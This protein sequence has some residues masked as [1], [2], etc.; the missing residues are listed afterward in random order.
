V[1]LGACAGVN[2]GI[3]ID[4]SSTVYPLTEAVAEEFALSGARTP[5]RVGISG[6]GGG[7]EKFCRGEIDVANASR[8]MRDRERA[9]CAAQGIDDIIE[10]QVA[11]DALTVVVSPAN[12]WAQCLTVEEL[13]SIF[14]AGG[15]TT[16]S[17]V[18]PEFPDERIRV[19]HPGADSGT[20]DYFVEAVIG[21]DALHR[22]DGTA[23]EDDNVLLQGVANDAYSIGYFGYA[24][25]REAGEQ[26]RAAA[27]DDGEGCVE[28]TYENAFT[29][30]YTPLSRP[31]LLYTREQTLDDP[32]AL[33][34]VDFY[35]AH[36]AQLA[37]EVGYIALTE[38]QLARQRAE[39][40]AIAARE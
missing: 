2:D 15:A 33:A 6:T 32:E 20:F 3:R 19:Y 4:G 40:A 39:L 21:S 11:I 30:A 16:W 18:R 5:V 25:F 1:L 23:S 24:Y 9:A 7:I 8:E 17:D 27:I 12:D 38:E 28:P 36:S 37:E 34:F 29:G 22:P 26:L 10:L 31:L 13:Q 14:A 35:L